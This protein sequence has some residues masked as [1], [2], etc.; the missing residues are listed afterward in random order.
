MI[1]ALLFSVAFLAAPAAGNAASEAYCTQWAIRASDNATTIRQVDQRWAW[2]LNQDEEPPLVDGAVKKK[3]ARAAGFPG[4][5]RYRSYDPRHHTFID[6]NRVR[7][8]C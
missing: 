8:A 4:C 3:P 1:R 6:F 7:R 2:C 5:R